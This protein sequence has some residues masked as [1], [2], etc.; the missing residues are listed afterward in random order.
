[1]LDMKDYRL[2]SLD[3]MR[4]YFY[5]RWGSCKSNLSLSALVAPIRNR[6]QAKTLWGLLTCPTVHDH[7]GLNG[8]GVDH[9]RRLLLVDHPVVLG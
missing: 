2:D 8:V 4:E 1:M 5:T 6:S 3:A 9:R 7:E